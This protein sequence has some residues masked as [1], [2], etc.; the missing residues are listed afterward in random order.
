M[1]HY[2]ILNWHIK[3]LLYIVEPPMMTVFDKILNPSVFTFLSVCLS[4]YYG[5]VLRQCIT[6]DYNGVYYGSVSRNV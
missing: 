1:W 6:V 5:S 2:W 4:V 3:L